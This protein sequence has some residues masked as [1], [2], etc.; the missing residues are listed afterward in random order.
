M[1]GTPKCGWCFSLDTQA[2]LDLVQ[3]LACGHHTTMTGEKAVSSSL[4]NEGVTVADL[5]KKGKG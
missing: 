5:S 3:C 2:G 1:P 4:A